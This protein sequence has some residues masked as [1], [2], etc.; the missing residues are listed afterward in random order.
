MAMPM[1]RVNKLSLKKTESAEFSAKDLY[2]YH[3]N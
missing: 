1:A 3:E 2:I